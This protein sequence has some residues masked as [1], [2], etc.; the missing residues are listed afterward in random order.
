MYE[1]PDNT[2]RQLRKV[3]SG[4]ALAVVERMDGFLKV[5]TEDGIEGWA[6]STFLV[7]DLPASNKLA[8][9]E[10][11]NSSLTK[12]YHD[13]ENKLKASKKKVADLDRQMVI[14][15]KESTQHMQSNE[16]LSRVRE[17][18]E[19]NMELAQQKVKELREQLKSYDQTSLQN[20][21]T[22]KEI[23]N[24]NLEMFAERKS[25]NG[26]IPLVWAISF[27]V[28]VLIL[29]FIAGLWWVDRRIRKRHGG[30]RI[31]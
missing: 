29:G 31:Y 9:L 28:V 13:L 11:K 2:S 8:Q 10:A 27:S 14:Y 5:R 3:M 25:F 17:E 15:K 7:A 20:K 19:K 24:Q 4:E 16:A 26:G 1:F 30:Y 23:L 18:S 12:E 22:T 6:K 21:Q